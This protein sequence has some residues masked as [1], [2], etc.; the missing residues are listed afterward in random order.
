MRPISF[1]GCNTIYGKGQEEYQQLPAMKMPDGEVI[2]CWELTEE[3][4]EVV[5]KSGKIY[6]QQLT[7]NQPLQPIMPVV[8]LGDNL[9]LSG[10]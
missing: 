5:C 7:F 2:T 6:F 9:N 4:L 3:E 8:E 1:P 10:I